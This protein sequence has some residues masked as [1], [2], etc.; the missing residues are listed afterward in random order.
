MSSDTAAYDDLRRLAQDAFAEALSL[1]F[2]D[3]CAGCG[4]LDVAL[5]ASCRGQLRP[6]VVAGEVDGVP[7]RSGLVFDAVPARVL[8]AL[9]EQGRTAFAR[10]LAPALAAAVVALDE[11]DAVIVP[12]PTSRAAMRRRGY[13]VA[14]LLARRAG[15]EPRRLLRAARPVADQRALGRRARE[16]NVAGSMAVTHPSALAGRAVILVDDVSTTGATL[17]EAARAVRAAGARVVGAATVAAT[18]RR[19]RSGW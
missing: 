4:A 6:R 18:P 8:R 19:R 2:P 11:P 5:C 13:R 3:A 10:S 16:A 12:V 9:K 17:A 1:V 15:L 7:L 14:E